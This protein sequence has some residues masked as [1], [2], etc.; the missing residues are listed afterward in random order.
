MS[1]R[2]D[3]RSILPVVLAA[4]GVI[5]ILGA[6]LWYLN[7]FG[8]PQDALAT[9]PALAI[10][11]PE[12]KRVN[13][14]DARAAYEMKSAVFVDVRGDPYYTEGHIPGALSIPLN[15]LI[16]HLDELNPKDWIIPYCT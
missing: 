12:V 6:A 9:T 16:Q 7:P 15:D 11:Y 3:P 2:R 1:N 14:A 13:L 4:A 8:L 5:L 10:P